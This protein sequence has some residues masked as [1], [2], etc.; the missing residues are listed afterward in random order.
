MLR[1]HACPS[2]LIRTHSELLA[3]PEVIDVRP[4]T[5]DTPAVVAPIAQ[6][7]TSLALPWALLPNIPHYEENPPDVPALWAYGG[8]HTTQNSRERHVSRKIAWCKLLICAPSLNHKHP[9]KLNTLRSG[10]GTGVIALRTLISRR[11][12]PN[13]SKMTLSGLLLLLRLGRSGWPVAKSQTARNWT[14]WF[15]Q[16]ARPCDLELHWN[17]PYPISAPSAAM[18]D[19]MNTP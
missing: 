9:I 6:I 5:R 7:W 4:G 1:Q 10:L 14:C 13:G 19:W 8:R 2:C 18:V 17:K 16:P 11:S 3:H 15:F 12:A